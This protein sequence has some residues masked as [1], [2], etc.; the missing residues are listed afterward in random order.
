[1]IVLCMENT[2]MESRGHPITC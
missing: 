1:M 2:G